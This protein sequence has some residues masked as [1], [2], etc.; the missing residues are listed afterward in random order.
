MGNLKAALRNAAFA[1]SNETPFNSNK[2]LPFLTGKTHPEI[3]PTPLPIRTPKDFA[4]T[5]IWEKPLI[6]KLP[7]RF[8]FRVIDL[9]AASNTID[10]ITPLS[11]NFKPN[12]KVFKLL[13]L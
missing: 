11:N 4:V 12:L 10:D 13:V 6:F 1:K 3:L 8:N 9:R 2:I 7:N 5:G